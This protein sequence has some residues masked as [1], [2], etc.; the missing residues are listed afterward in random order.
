MPCRAALAPFW[1]KKCSAEVSAIMSVVA[2]MRDLTMFFFVMV[3][4]SRRIFFYIDLSL[5]HA[6][7]Q[8]PKT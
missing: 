4:Y 6:K 8:H 1:R 7:N 5:F 2:N 3:V